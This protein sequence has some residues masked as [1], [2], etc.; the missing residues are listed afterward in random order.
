MTA[1]FVPPYPV[2]HRSKASLLKR[3]VTGWDSWIHTLF[4][5]S[6]TMKLG[7]IRLPKLDFF[8]AN[9][10]AIVA[11]VMDDADGRF[12]KHPLLREMLDPLIGNSVFAANGSDWAEQRQ[13]VNPAFAHTNLRRA[14]P[15]MRAAVD[16]TLARIAGEDL[17]RPVAIDRHM[18]HVAADIIF[19]T[20][21]SVPLDEAG[22]IE[23]H[24][25]FNAYQRGIQPSMM[26]SIYRLP[27]LFYRRRAVRAAARVHALFAPIVAARHAAAVRGEEGPEED[28]LATLL[29]ARHPITGERFTVGELIDQI[30]TIFLA[31]HETSASAMTWALYLIAESPDLQRAIRAEIAEVAG[32]QPF[33]DGVIRNLH[34]TRD[35]FRETLRLYPPVSFFIREVTRPTV[36]RKKAMKP[37]SMIVVSPWLIQRNADHWPCPHAFKP[38]RF[39]DPAEAAACRH[40]YLP[41]G[42]GPRICIG[43][44]FAQQEALLVLASIVRRFRL[45][46]PADD[47]PVPVSRLTLRPKHGLRLRLT[48][49]GE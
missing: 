5:K 22:G 2:P 16:D 18:T 8:I 43:A 36:M 46:S 33:D 21:F 12:P 29:E 3:F 45:E 47:K 40:A 13:M 44:G 31:G 42:R 20:I 10:P 1:P 6:Y 15:V 37:G 34:R 26:L 30:S 38:E 25:A 9:D 41:F 49:V 27:L 4:E 24:E 11:Q 7:D 23:I 19:R 48:P 28:I 14:L 35:V 39:S 32:D 17:A